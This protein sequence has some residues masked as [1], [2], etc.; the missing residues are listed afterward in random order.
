MTSLL[1]RY[2][3]LRSMGLGESRAKVAAAIEAARSAPDMTITR[4]T[5]ELDQLLAAEKETPTR[6]GGLL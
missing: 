2:R 6:P 4:A 3:E 1:R 5:Q